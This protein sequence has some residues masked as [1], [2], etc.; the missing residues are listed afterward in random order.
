M[1]TIVALLL[2]LSC[3]QGS[4]QVLNR[5]LP[6]SF[7]YPSVI[8]YGCLKVVPSVRSAPPAETFFDS[9]V[10]VA[11]NGATGLVRIRAWRIGCHEPNASAIM[12]NFDLG[13]GSPEIRYP[14]VSLVTPDFEVRPAGLFAFARTD[15]YDSRGASLE[16]MTDRL[17]SRLVEGF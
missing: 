12:L 8:Q 11:D 4:A 13:S 5:D 7:T 10:L 14:E 1:K 15:F 9:Q 17:L 16:P 2:I 6:N 3:L